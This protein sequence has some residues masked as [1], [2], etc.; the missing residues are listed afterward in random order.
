MAQQELGHRTTAIFL[1]SEEPILDASTLKIKQP[2]A[3]T[4]TLLLHCE[5][6]ERGPQPGDSLRSLINL[7]SRISETD[8]T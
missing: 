6:V 8:I 2:E 1:L 5:L 4:A 3:A 7:A